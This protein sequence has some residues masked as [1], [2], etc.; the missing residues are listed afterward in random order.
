[1]SSETRMSA[2]PDE[3]QLAGLLE[4]GLEPEARGRIERH[5]AGCSTC[6]DVLAAALPAEAPV[7]VEPVVEL[8]AEWTRRPAHGSRRVRRWAV[9]AAVVLAA[10]VVLAGSL[11]RPLADQATSALTRIVGRTLGIPVRADSIWASLGSDVATVVIHVHGVAIGKEQNRFVSAD[12]VVLSIAPA[13]SLGTG[14]VVQEMR[15]LRPEIRLAAESVIAG[16]SRLGEP[17]VLGLFSTAG[18]ADLVDGRAVLALPG[19]ESLELTELNGG[20]QRTGEDARL[21]LGGRLAGGVITISGTFSGDGR[22]LAVTLGG[23]AIDLG[24]L[25]RLTGGRLHGTAEI[26]ADVSG[27]PAAPRVDGRI[28]VQNGR[29]NST[30]LASLPT[31]DQTI[32]RSVRPSLAGSDLAFDDGRAI[33][34]WRDGVWRLPRV[35]VSAGGLLAGGR[36]RIARGGVVDGRGTVRIPADVVGA[37]VAIEPGLASLR[38]VAGTATLPFAVSGPFDAPRFTLAAPPAAR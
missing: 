7:R 29:W 24:A 8:P 38:D 27:S 15:V 20:I 23:R 2:C 3:E 19:G 21:V 22:S 13:A 26:R 30:P 25:S 11:R 28:S 36:A 10:G 37:L 35:Y 4:G 12:E 1:M 34:A 5:I 14:S 17:E 18:S 16:L 32:L 9:A 33:F 31:I 6:L